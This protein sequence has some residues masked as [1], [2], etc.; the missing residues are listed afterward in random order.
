MYSFLIRCSLLFIDASCCIQVI[1]FRKSPV[2]VEAFIPFNKVY[3]SDMTNL[4]LIA[5][6]AMTPCCFRWV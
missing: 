6:L 4:L 1:D 3:C 5:V 2:V